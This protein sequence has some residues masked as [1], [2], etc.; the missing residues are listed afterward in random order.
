[1]AAKPRKP[2]RY[3][4][5]I[6]RRFC[7]LIAAGN[8]RLSLH[9]RPGMPRVAAVTVWL[10]KYPEFARLYRAA[11]DRR[12]ERAAKAGRRDEGRAGGFSTY[13]P[14]RAEEICARVAEGWSLRAISRRPGGPG[15]TTI[16][17]W[18][19]EHEDFR[20]AYHAAWEQHAQLIA[21]ETVEIADAALGCGW[22]APDGR[23][24]V[25]ARDALLHAKLKI[26]ARNGRLGRLTPKSMVPKGPEPKP[27]RTH[28]A[29]LE[30]LG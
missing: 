8:S 19:T 4:L 28:E 6:A 26:D 10:R 25:S 7:G 5:K 15:L 9:R 11:C 24:P 27:E 21:E 1:M 20:R 13:T 14:E 22:A 17:N 30:L 2:I 3:S 18:Q 16:A 23:P 29:W 12:A